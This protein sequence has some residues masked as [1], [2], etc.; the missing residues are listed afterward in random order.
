[1]LEA[2]RRNTK[3]ILWITVISFVLLM[4]LVWGA[5]L[6][7]NRSGPRADTIGMVNGDRILFSDYQQELGRN[8]EIARSQGRELQPSDELM[9]EEQTWSN[10]VTRRLLMQEAVRRNMLVRDSEVRSVL[11]NNPPA[12]I[13]QDPSFR[14]KNG[15]FDLATYKATIQD[16]QLPEELLLQ[17]EDAVR[18][19]LPIQ[20]LQDVIV[21]SAKVSDEEVR[22]AYQDETEKVGISYVVVEAN[23]PTANS[24]V[25]DAELNSYYEANRAKLAMPKRATLRYVMVPRRAT[26]QDSLTTR[27]DLAEL[28]EEARVAEAAR[29]EG[30]EDLEHSDFATLAMSFSDAPNADDGGLNPEFVNPAQLPQ[31]YAAAVQG[32]GVGDVSQPFL[33]GSQFHILQVAAEKMEAGERQVQLRDISVRIAPS[34]STIVNAQE[35]LEAVRRAAQTE[36]LEKAAAGA[37]L[38]VK[39]ASGV[40]AS[41]IV[42]GLSA[43]PQVAAFA[44]ENPPGTVSRVYGTNTAWFVVEIAD[45]QPEGVPPLAEIRDRLTN[46]VVRERRFTEARAT[47][48]RISGRVKGGMS[49]EAAAAAESV[50]VQTTPEFSRRSGV[51]SMGRD[52]DVVAEAFALPVGAVSAPVKGIRGW[53]ILR[54]D[55]HVPV[56]WAAFEPRKDQIRQSL[57]NL[58]QGQIFN[59]WIENLRSSAKITDYR[60]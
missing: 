52:A 31:P 40:T 25:S 18:R 50:P 32:L 3:V 4:F 41:G 51:P 48:D 28:A 37:G 14:D 35:R 13:T 26:A 5:D 19:D 55:Q 7:G 10:I 58:R 22:R 34:D 36:G 16:P 54:V 49:L 30:R 39:V 44:L 57:L 17:L 6:Q 20:K 53:V 33:E 1:M 23:R 29:R 43:I 47:A 45:V 60:M 11:L 21:S 46:D 27:S 15:N 8:R 2:M 56:D 12:F 9:L 24:D 38:E 59:G 42:P